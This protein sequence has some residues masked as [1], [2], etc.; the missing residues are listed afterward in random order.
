MYY[1]FVISGASGVKAY[2]VQADS[3]ASAKSILKAQLQNLTGVGATDLPSL[4]AQ[5]DSTSSV[6]QTTIPTFSNVPSVAVNYTGAGAGDGLVP[7]A[8]AEV[9]SDFEEASYLGGLR[10]AGR[11]PYGAFGKYLRERYAPT[12]ATFRFNELIGGT[13]PAGLQG[14][15]QDAAQKTGRGVNQQ[16]L[17]TFNNLYAE[18]GKPV[19][20]FFKPTFTQD[21]RD[22][23]F[24]VKQG[25][26]GGGLRDDAL[27][28][29][30]SGVK[31]RISPYFADQAYDPGRIKQDFNEQ[32]YKNTG[33]G[34]NQGLNFAEYLKKVFGL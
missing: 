26:Q 33:A 24:N 18:S 7:P 28:L 3:E 14:F 27:Q 10:N 1:S 8:P 22:Q 19:D 16:A 32:L 15:T 2:I 21:L 9:Q 5:V 31:S 29:A 20:A 13:N 4:Q 17:D 11:N 12:R 30:L 6:G 23:L 25:D 34:G